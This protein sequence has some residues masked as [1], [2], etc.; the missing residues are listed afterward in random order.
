MGKP[1]GSF[2][3]ICEVIWALPSQGGRAAEAPLIGG[4]PHTQRAACEC[5]MSG[6]HWREEHSPGEQ[7]AQPDGRRRTLNE[8]TRKGL[9][10]VLSLWPAGDKTPVQ[11]LL[12]RHSCSCRTMG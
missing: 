12:D 11:V 10:V 4:W 9:A 2:F 8:E 3:S 5:L 1:P 6:S 7:T